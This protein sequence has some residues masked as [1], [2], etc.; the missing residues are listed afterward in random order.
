MGIV[1]DA[2]TEGSFCKL[3]CGS[4]MKWLTE[5]FAKK[6]LEKECNKMLRGTCVLSEGV[7]WMNVEYYGT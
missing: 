6:V 1:L 3:Q 5:I 2:R 7:V 4:L